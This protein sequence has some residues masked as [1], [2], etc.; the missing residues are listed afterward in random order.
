[1]SPYNPDQLLRDLD[2]SSD[3]E[4]IDNKHTH[5]VDYSQD[6]TTSLAVNDPTEFRLFYLT[7]VLANRLLYSK[8]VN[9]IY[10]PKKEQLKKFKDQNFEIDTILRRLLNEALQAIIQAACQYLSLPNR[11]PLTADNINSVEVAISAKASDLI[12]EIITAIQALPANT[13][14]RN[15]YHDQ[16]HKL[17][18]TR[19]NTLLPAWL[20]QERQNSNY[21][22]RAPQK[23][24]L[25]DNIENV[26]PRF[27]SLTGKTFVD[28][29]LEAISVRLSN[30][31]LPKQNDPKRSAQLTSSFKSLAATAW[32]YVENA[33]GG[34]S[35]EKILK[36]NSASL[37][38]LYIS[39]IINLDYSE[40]AF[41]GKEAALTT[42]A[43]QEAQYVNPEQR[44]DNTPLLAYLTLN[45][46]RFKA[47]VQHNINTIVQRKFAIYFASQR[48]TL[49]STYSFI[50]KNSVAFLAHLRLIHRSLRREAKNLSQNPF[51]RTI[52]SGHNP[53][54]LHVQC[55]FFQAPPVAAL[56]TQSV[57]ANT[58]ARSALV[59][60]GG[61]YKEIYDELLKI[62]N[63]L[64]KHHLPCDGAILASTLRDL[65]QG[66]TDTDILLKLPEEIREYVIERLSTITYLLFGCEVAR[67]PASLI[68]HQ[69]ALDLVIAK[70]T[71]WHA[72]L[73]ASPPY[74]PM[75]AGDSIERAREMNLF[76]TQFNN[77]VAYYTYD[78]SKEFDACKKNNFSSMNLLYQAE[79]RLIRDWLKFKNIAKDAH[80][81][82]IAKAITANFEAWFGHSFAA[83]FSNVAEPP[84]LHQA[85]RRF[86]RA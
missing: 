9:Q 58:L 2:D 71:T 43:W 46:V 72:L 5:A 38:R 82:T 81:N 3:E 66:K 83:T 37:K 15:M 41:K 78:Y 79:T 20:L 42:L 28:I 52:Y 34:S 4:T 44:V 74:L 19:L 56:E 75:A 12:D 80:P 7:H 55:Q 54:K 51:A 48:P 22:Y 23:Y 59:D 32:N 29:A 13:D 16:L 63:E 62:T 24:A 40:L 11:Q 26:M 86:K 1:M 35:A 67:N 84:A 57:H 64:R 50:P 10:Y 6:V 25:I 53:K 47:L 8:E 18:E 61:N 36:L 49:G 65:L 45:N 21:I 68:I 14:N 69:M 77:N 73:A 31:K 76:F 39:N 85:N 30:N 27:H 33:R 70:K 17:I 60:N